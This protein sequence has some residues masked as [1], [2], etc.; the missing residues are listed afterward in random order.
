MSLD[1]PASILSV[2]CSTCEGI[3]TVKHE[4]EISRLCSPLKY[5]AE[6]LVTYVLNIPPISHFRPGTVWR[7]VLPQRSIS[8]F[9]WKHKSQCS[10]CHVNNSSPISV[11]TM[12]YTVSSIKIII[13]VKNM[14]E[15]DSLWPG[16]NLLT[17]ASTN[18]TCSIFKC[19]H[20]LAPASG[21][22]T[23]PIDTKGTLSNFVLM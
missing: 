9:A 10:C 3:S 14:H 1:K 23:V 22:S 5:E 7:K 15:K 19:R 4:L 8:L 2:Q 12:I 18:W 11:P 20:L 13:N 16:G 21:L 17:V 6:P